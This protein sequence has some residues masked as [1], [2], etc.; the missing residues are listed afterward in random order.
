[1][2]TSIFCQNS[3]F[4]IIFEEKVDLFK[5]CISSS[6]ICLNFKLRFA[7]IFL[8]LLSIVSGHKH[9][10]LLHV[11][12]VVSTNKILDQTNVMFSTVI[13]TCKVLGSAKGPIGFSSFPLL[14]IP[15]GEHLPISKGASSVD[16]PDHS[17]LSTSRQQEGQVSLS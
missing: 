4:F 7:Q 3:I 6:D 15:F 9:E 1:M 17:V 10:L 11:F 13:D 5:K 16:Q 14:H 2:S 12:L 8:K